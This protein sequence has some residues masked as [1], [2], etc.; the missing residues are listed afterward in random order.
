MPNIFC[1][2]CVTAFDSHFGR[3]HI[4]LCRAIILLSS[5]LIAGSE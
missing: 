4:F 3:P 1:E 2:S 5:F